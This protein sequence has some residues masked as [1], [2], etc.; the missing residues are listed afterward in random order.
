MAEQVLSRATL[1]QFAPLPEGDDQYPVEYM[2]ANSAI[3]LR[4]DDA[5]VVIGVCDPSD[6]GLLGFLRDFHEKPVS[7]LWIERAE[8]SAYLGKRLS[9]VEGLGTKGAVQTNGSRR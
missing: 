1:T 9:A 3:K 8:L 7:F 2:D 4:E 6:E 5:S